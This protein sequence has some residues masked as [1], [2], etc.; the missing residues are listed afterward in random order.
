MTNKEKQQLTAIG[1]LVVVIAIGVLLG[2]PYVK[3]LKEYDRITEQRLS[4]IS[5]LQQQ[6]ANKPALEASIESVDALME[7]SNIFMRVANQQ[8]ADAELLS[9]AKKIIEEAGGEVSSVNPLRAQGKSKSS[10]VKINMTITHEGL[11]EVFKQMS[12]S[13]PL[14][15]I[16]EMQAVPVFKRQGNIMIETG[17]FRVT[18]GVEA[19]FLPKV[20]G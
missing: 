15:T 6:I 11:V 7:K 9:I 1:T 20:I 16:T 4:Q 2:V 3:K 14:M 17:R 12:V 18:L 10:Q 8:A 5:A 13:K 19:F